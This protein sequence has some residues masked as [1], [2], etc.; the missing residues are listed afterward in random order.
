MLITADL[1]RAARERAQ[2]SCRQSAALVYVATRTWYSC[3]SGQTRLSAPLFALYLHKSRVKPIPLG[4]RGEV[5][6][7]GC[8]PDINILKAQRQSRRLSQAQAAQLVHVT[9]RTWQNWE[10]GRSKMHPAA[11]ELFLIKA[12]WIPVKALSTTPNTQAKPQSRPDAD[13]E[14]VLTGQAVSAPEPE[15]DSDD[16]DYWD[17]RS[18]DVTLTTEQR[19]HARNRA[20]EIVGA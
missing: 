5:A 18:H 8:P 11:Y 3:E 7:R 6:C 13:I 15:H 10:R 16:F 9:E 19:Q 17:A 4:M 20:Y 12:G 1:L 14:R 2:L